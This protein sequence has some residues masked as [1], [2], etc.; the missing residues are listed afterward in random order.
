MGWRRGPAGSLRSPFLPPFCSVFF[1]GWG[2][3]GRETAGPSSLARLPAC[4]I[5]WSAW[6]A[7]A[8]S[9][10]P[11]A[12]GRLPCGITGL[13]RG[14]RADAG[15]PA[16][17][18]QPRCRLTPTSPRCRLHSAA[19]CHRPEAMCRGAR[20]TQ[21]RRGPR[22][23]LCRRRLALRSLL[24]RDLSEGA[25]FAPAAAA[26]GGPASLGRRR[27]RCDVSRRGTGW[28][29]G[30]CDGG[31]AQGRRGPRPPGLPRGHHAASLP[32]WGSQSQ[33]AQSG[34]VGATCS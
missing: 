11:A 14:P 33:G 3:H 7:R 12:R 30:A 22:A 1:R 2:R 9:G 34:A 25:P 6:A 23:S 17:A 16:G 10:R 19:G 8:P 27:Q 26:P 20:P 32:R 15:G 29:L 13:R 31:R 28:R 4:R 18:P 21:G 24:R 5:A